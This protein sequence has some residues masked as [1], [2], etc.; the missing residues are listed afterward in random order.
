M[1]VKFSGSIVTNGT[2]LTIDLAE[3]L[4]E[5][6]INTFQLTFD[7]SEDEH[8]R[9]RKYKNGNHTYH[10]VLRALE[11]LPEKSSASIRVHLYEGNNIEN[12]KYL[13]IDISNTKSKCRK[14]IYF[15]TVHPLTTTCASIA[16]SAY[17]AWIPQNTAFQKIASLIRFALE[18]GLSIHT[19]TN[20][21][22]ICGA[23][24]RNSLVIEPDGTLKKCWLEVGN[25]DLAIG[26]IKKPVEI[27][28]NNMNL[29]N[30]L[31]Y[32]P[33]AMTDSECHACE[34]FERCYGG[35]PY[36][37]R[38]GVKKPHR[39][40]PCKGLIEEFLPKLVDELRAKGIGT[41]DAESGLLIPTGSKISIN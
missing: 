5:A 11:C 4:V 26:T 32:D 28:E 16:E 41:Y 8:N 38:K 2:L 27:S 15:T 30:W 22:F 9:F 39:C 17:G 29:V 19:G 14:T 10:L 24:S 34:W 12:L 25:P 36:M 7:D 23:V 37:V 35:C 21:Q 33:V 1:N 13:F 3:Q 31:T 6:K 18:L 40:H 20:T